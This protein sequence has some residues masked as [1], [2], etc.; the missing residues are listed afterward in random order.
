MQYGRWREK[1]CSL[2]IVFSNAQENSLLVSI[3]LPL[4]SFVS[5]SVCH[6]A[7]AST[8]LLPSPQC[9]NLND[10]SFLVDGMVCSSDAAS[11]FSR[12]IRKETSRKHVRTSFLTL[13]HLI[14]SQL[15]P[16]EA[17]H[18]VHLGRGSRHLPRGV[19]PHVEHRHHRVGVRRR[20][21]LPISSSNGIERPWRRCPSPCSQL[22][23]T[24]SC[25]QFEENENVLRPPPSPSSQST[26]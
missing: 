18:H 13:S 15:S 10:L 1:R 24:L 14:D 8:L 2:A 6:A 25:L 12:P 19:R 20:K 9:H 21:G 5:V 11:P 23:P 3:V 7:T 22:K 16:H 17:I 26:W 4:D